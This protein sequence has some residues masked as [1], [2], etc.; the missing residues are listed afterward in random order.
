MKNFIKLV[1]EYLG[2]S[3]FDIVSPLFQAW[4]E[5][6]EAELNE[7]MREILTKYHEKYLKFS[8]KVF[9]DL[10]LFIMSTN[11]ILVTLFMGR[12]NP[13]NGIAQLAILSIILVSWGIKWLTITYEI[14]HKH[15]F[16]VFILFFGFIL[17]FENTLFKEFKI[18]E[19]WPIFDFFWTLICITMV[20][21][22]E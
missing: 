17:I 13:H 5:I 12:N 10:I 22:I 6:Q 7:E 18:Y 19:I 15:I 3:L 1:P 11:L 9:C 16:P 2:K 21:N 4:R 14:A 20:K 8:L